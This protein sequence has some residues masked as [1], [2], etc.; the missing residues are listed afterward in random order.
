MIPRRMVLITS[1]EKPQ[2]WTHSSEDARWNTSNVDPKDGEATRR[3][4]R[5]IA[6]SVGAAGTLRLPRAAPKVP[7]DSKQ[8]QQG[9]IR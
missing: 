8:I 7:Q 4:N 2:L 6:P 3:P 9:A 1:T 5:G